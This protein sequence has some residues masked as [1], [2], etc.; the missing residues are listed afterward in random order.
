MHKSS[1]VTRVLGGGGEP[2]R[3]HHPVGWQWHPDESD[4][5]FVAEF[6]S[7]L[8]KRSRRM[9]R[10]TEWWCFEDND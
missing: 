9:S 4:N 7:V 6:Y 3:R 10:G 2:P 8:E 5:F 1:G